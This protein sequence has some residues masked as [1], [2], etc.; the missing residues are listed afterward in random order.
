MLGCSCSG[1]FVA[2]IGQF[3]GAAASPATPRTLKIG[4]SVGRNGVN[5]KADTLLVQ[6]ALNA[7]PQAAG[8]PAMPL[9][10]DGIVGPL[11]CAAIRQFQQRWFSGASVDG[12]VDP[13]GQ[14]IRKLNE[15]GSTIIRNGTGVPQILPVTP[16]M[17]AALNAVADA[18]QLVNGALVRLGRITPLYNTG[19]TSFASGNAEQ[20]HFEWHFRA[21]K[22][23][24]PALHVRSVTAMFE[25]MRKCLNNE[26]PNIPFA[27]L[28]PL[29]AMGLATH[30][31][32]AFAPHGGFAATM[33][34]L[35]DHDG[36]ATL[37]VPSAFIYLHPGKMVTPSVLVHELSH[38]CGG[39]PEEAS[40]VGHYSNITPWPNGMRDPDGSRNYR[41]MTPS[42]ALTNAWSYQLYASPDIPQSK[43]P[44]DFMPVPGL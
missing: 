9:A 32:N 5:Q 30:T 12:R 34:D 42:D 4:R 21:H 20:R 25:R 36:R 26:R 6:A 44:D 39:K 27:S 38:F 35:S 40:V 7:V 15:L 1:D 11:T 8:G 24:K 23:A 16:E 29:F 2:R 19:Q 33:T 31:Y 22:V 37:K 13:D 10:A 3:P 41:D 14:S 43:V 18:K 28:V 17:Q